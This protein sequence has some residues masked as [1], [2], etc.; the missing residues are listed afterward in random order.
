MARQMLA[1]IPYTRVSTAT[2]VDARGTRMP[3]GG[4]W[5]EQS[6]HSNIITSML[7]FIMMLVLFSRV[8]EQ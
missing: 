5:Q 7:G 8:S 2:A 6:I 4:F 3:N 1:T